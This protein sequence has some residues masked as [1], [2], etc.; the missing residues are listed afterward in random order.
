MKLKI[1]FLLLNQNIGYGYT[2]E[3]SQVDGPFEHPK[4]IIKL[5][6]EKIH[7]FRNLSK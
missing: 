1:K 3:L 6:A 2:K 5:N 7:V 4:Q